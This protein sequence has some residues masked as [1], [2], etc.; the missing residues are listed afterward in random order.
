[1][2]SFFTVVLIHAFRLFFDRSDPLF[3]ATGMITLAFVLGFLISGM[4]AHH[5]YPEAANMGMWL[6]IFLTFRVSLER[7]RLYS[8]VPDYYFSCNIPLNPSISQTKAYLNLIN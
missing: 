2:I 3:A 4:G 5:F 1:M 6:S 8:V 7:K